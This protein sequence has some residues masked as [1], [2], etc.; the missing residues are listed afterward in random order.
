M[1][2]CRMEDGWMLGDVGANAETAYAVD[3]RS[4]GECHC[5]DGRGH[6]G[7]NGDYG[8]ATVAKA[9]TSA[10]AAATTASA[11]LQTPVENVARLEKETK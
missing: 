2:R 6:G 4:G 10:A 11:Q 9:T 7:S 5:D 1:V 3:N 8:D